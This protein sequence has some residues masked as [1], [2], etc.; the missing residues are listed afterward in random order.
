MIALNKILKVA[1]AADNSMRRCVVFD[2]KHAIAMPDMEWAVGVAC[3]QKRLTRPVQVSVEALKKYLLLNAELVV[4]DEGLLSASGQL[5][6]HLE[7]NDVF[8]VLA[9]L[10]SEPAGDRLNFDLDLNALDRTLIAA[11][12][13]DI[14]I[15]LNGVAMDFSKGVLVGTNGHRIHLFRDCVPKVDGG[16]VD[17]YPTAPLDFVVRSTASHARVTVFEREILMVAGDVFIWSKCI[18]GKY[19]D[20]M[21]VVPAVSEIWMSVDPTHLAN[22]ANAL[23]R[24]QKKLSFPTVQLHASAGLLVSCEPPHERLPVAMNL[25]NHDETQGACWM[26]LNSSYLADAADCVTKGARWHFLSGQGLLVSEDNF[27]ALVLMTR[28]RGID[29]ASDS[30]PEAGGVPKVKKTPK[31]PVKTA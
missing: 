30:T 21:R 7:A 26:N 16:R 25:R 19:P 11:A 8:V 2:G 31:K 3:V 4:T 20:Y 18:D 13:D 6:P 17:V 24:T 27:V 15:Y 23:G 9:G 29:L 22:A 5:L 14:R 28:S 12:K 1:A 10:P